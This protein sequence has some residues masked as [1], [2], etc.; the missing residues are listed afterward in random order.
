MYGVT[1]VVPCAHSV[2]SDQTPSSHDSETSIWTENSTYHIQNS[3]ARPAYLGYDSTS[4]RKI[5]PIKRLKGELGRYVRFLNNNIATGA[6]PKDLI[7]IP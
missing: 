4:I 2:G 5:E 7:T 3:Q 6:I 1:S